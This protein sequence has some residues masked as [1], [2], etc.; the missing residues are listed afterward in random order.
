MIEGV[1]GVL[2]T[3]GLSKRYGSNKALASW[4]GGRLIEATARVM[5]GLFRETLVAAK[6]VE[7][8]RFLKTSGLRII[9][10]DSTRS[11]PAVG[12]L[13]GLREARTERVFV[14]A[15]DMPL[16][17]PA[18]VRRL[19]A[20]SCGVDAAVPVWQGAAQPLC[21]VY[22]QSC[23]RPLEEML[24]SG[25]F[26]LKELFADVETRFLRGHGL[27]SVDPEGLSFADIDT[28]KDRAR[29]EALAG[30]GDSV[31]AG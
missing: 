30:R 31:Y 22:A 8:Y 10:D 6:N 9:V 23:L 5:R 3:G 27:E 16:I 26:G 28:V 25:N 21:A 29:V 11:H 1:S 18:L 7:D 14:C 12:V 15:C 17:R 24:E 2:L 19:C 4:D 20:E 13:T